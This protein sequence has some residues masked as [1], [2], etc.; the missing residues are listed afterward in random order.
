[1]A[2]EEPQLSPGPTVG[3]ITAL[4]P[5]IAKPR[6]LV[7]PATE[8]QTN[9][10]R[11]PIIPFACWKVDHMR[12]AF[13]SSLPQPEMRKEIANLRVLVQ[14]HTK[15]LT[16]GGPPKSPLLSVFG[17]ADPTGSEA[18]NKILSGRRARSIYALLTR[19]VDM[20]QTLYNDQE[21]TADQW[22]QPGVKLMHKATNRPGPPPTDA[23]GRKALFQAYMDF[24][25]TGVSGEVF[26]VNPA[27][28]LGRGVD[29]GGK[30]DYQGCSEF[31]PLMLLS[32][33]DET[34]LAK[35]ERDEK[36]VVDRRVVILLY[37]PEIKVDPSRW[38]CPRATEG[39]DG[40]KKR[41]FSDSA[42]RL[43]RDPATERLYEKTHDTF[44]CR[45]YDRMIFNSPCERPNPGKGLAFLSV[46]VF[47]HARPM[48][49]VYVEFFRL[50]GNALGD[51]LGEPVLTDD[52]G[53]A[54]FPEAVPIGNYVARVEYQEPKAICTVFDPEDPEILV[55]PIGRPY[56]CV[57]GDI[58]FDPAGQQQ[59]A[60][61]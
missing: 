55:L 2:A 19:K 25:C 60:D 27:D 42:N 13:D 29:K 18:Y 39:V 37:R 35:E 34:S 36:Y 32:Q 7:G 58:E 40:C 10:L 26:K 20:W 44:A 6:V 23:A 22:G 16:P 14:R 49:E 24:L 50:S 48:C 9:V 28:F 21:G 31:N 61:N 53:M 45:F 57:E 1:M 33:D 8:Q 12:F 51:P 52:T 30:A 46:R 4:H 54:Q 15:P 43:R 3:G 38:P 11:P 47:F 56:W 5:D 59:D 17:H 41:F